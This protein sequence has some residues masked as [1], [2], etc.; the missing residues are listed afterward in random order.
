M[1]YLGKIGQEESQ[2]KLKA[3]ESFLISENG[4]TL[5]RLLDGANVSYCWTQV[6]VNL[7]CQNHSICAVNHYISFQ[8]LQL[9]CKEYK[10]E[11]DNA[12]VVTDLKFILWYLKYMRM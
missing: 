7:L 3:E 4:Y 2:N 10:W 6:P 5:G 9:A 8:N 1:T 12:L 11:M